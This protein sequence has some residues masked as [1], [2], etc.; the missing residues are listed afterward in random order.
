[1][2]TKK[3]DFKVNL[4]SCQKGESKKIKFYKCNHENKKNNLL[5]RISF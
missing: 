3:N 1:M 5:N 4:D 2:K